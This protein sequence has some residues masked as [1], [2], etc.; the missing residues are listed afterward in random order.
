ML[1]A[2]LSGWYV[3]SRYSCNSVLL[4]YKR[5]KASLNE[6]LPIVAMLT[7]SAGVAMFTLIFI[8]VG[9]TFE[10]IFYVTSTFSF[11]SFLYSRFTSQTPLNV[12]AVPRII[13]T[14]I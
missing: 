13:F 5:A 2:I 4:L 8:M 7:A 10:I 6:S 9:Y 11:L 14:F 12:I 3:K 1:L